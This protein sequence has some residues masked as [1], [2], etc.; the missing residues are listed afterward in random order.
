LNSK[1]GECII[2]NWPQIQTQNRLKEVI[3]LISAN[4]EE[5]L[6]KFHLEIDEFYNEL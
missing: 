5:N 3:E 6:E 4:K 1:N 2:D